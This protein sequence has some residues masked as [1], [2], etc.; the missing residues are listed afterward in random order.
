[1]WPVHVE[2]ITA[3]D[4]TKLYGAALPALS[5][6]YAGYV[7]GDTGTSLT[8]PVTLATAATPTSG[9]GKYAIIPSGAT[10]AITPRANAAA[11]GDTDDGRHR[12][13]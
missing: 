10:A 4:K 1:M 8:T 5:A 11:R 6:S 3:N 7:N 13:I 12:P 2:Q 9:V